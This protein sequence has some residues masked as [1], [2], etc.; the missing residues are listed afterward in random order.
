MTILNQEMSKAFVSSL[1]PGDK[2]KQF[3]KATQLDQIQRDYIQ[4]GE[5]LK[6]M[7]HSIKRQNNRIEVGF[8]HCSL[9]F[10]V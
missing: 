10:C 5:S 8:A 9:V 7:A 4:V 1:D 2:Y 3:T 6:Q